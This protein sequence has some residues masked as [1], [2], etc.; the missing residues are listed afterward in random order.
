MVSRASFTLL[1]MAGG[2][3]LCELGCGN[4]VDPWA[5]PRATRPDAALGS[6]GSFDP[7]G[8]FGVGG[9]GLGGS[10]GGSDDPAGSGGAGETGGNGADGSVDTGGRAGFAGAD[11]RDAREAGGIFDSG[12]DVDS[13]GLADVG[14]TDATG[15]TADACAGGGSVLGTFYLSD[16]A[17]IGTPIN[18]FGPVE[19]NT[20]N[21]ESLAGDGHT[22][23]IE[24]V[25]YAKGIGAHA[26]SSIEYDLQGRCKT[27]TAFV[28]ADDEVASASI[29]FEVWV[30]G[31]RSYS[32]PNLVERGQAAAFVSVDVQCASR[33]RLVVTDGVLDGNMGDHADWADAKVSCARAPSDAAAP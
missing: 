3:A 33:I 14:S 29:T 6:G 20:S 13:G 4:G 28:G 7:S 12:R 32:S 27:F 5:V 21:G 16:L 10:F 15:A 2:C 19:R 31:K 25:T 9:S 8:T 22:I 11:A 1:A 23:S 18:G 30:D 26:N 17:W 24:G